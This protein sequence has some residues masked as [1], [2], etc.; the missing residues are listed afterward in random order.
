MGPHTQL[1]RLCGDS[2]Y[3]CSVIPGPRLQGRRHLSSYIQGT[4][5][6]DSLSPWWSISYVFA[7]CSE[8][9]LTHLTPSR[10]ITAGDISLCPHFVSFSQALALP[11]SWLSLPTTAP[12][13]GQ[14]P[15]CKL[16]PL[17]DL[18]LGPS[19]LRT[20]L[21]SLTSTCHVPTGP[22]SHGS[23]FRKEFS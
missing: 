13:T 15:V 14:P 19:Q 21:R 2:C 23:S 11:P 3:G 16:P 22:E 7:K 9:H 6:L 5:P 4:F 12:P 17:R 20:F 18:L 10:E 8:T 1:S